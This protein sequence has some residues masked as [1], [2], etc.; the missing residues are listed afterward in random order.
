MAAA[1]P[2]PQTPTA[3]ADEFEH[4]AAELVLPLLD[5]ATAVSERLANGEA[6]DPEF[7]AEMVQLWTQY[8][9]EIRAPRLE[10]YF[11]AHTAPV[12]A[13][14][15]HATGLRARLHPAG[16]NAPRGPDVAVEVREDR[17][18]L[19]QRTGTLEDAL[20][21]YRR[22]QFGSAQ[23]L[24]SLLRADAFA[25]RA[26]VRYEREAVRTARRR[27]ISAEEEDRLRRGLEA[28]EPVRVGLE[29]KVRRFLARPVPVAPH[30]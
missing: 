15:P 8:L 2:A 4:E 9:H 6:I 23:L 7:I 21:D 11:K 16:S 26:W 18:R 25:D 17:E 5:R 30:A 27:T 22:H 14:A 13:A 20:D 24:A 29:A 19:E 10:Q 1:S 3:V 12:P 28:T